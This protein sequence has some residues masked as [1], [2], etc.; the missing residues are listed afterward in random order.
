[1][2]EE[3]QKRSGRPCRSVLA[4]PSLTSSVVGLQTHRAVITQA[5]ERE[6]RRLD[7]AGGGMRA[8]LEAWLLLLVVTVVRLDEQVA[9]GSECRQT[10]QGWVGPFSVCPDRLRPPLWTQGSRGSWPLSLPS[11]KA[12]LAF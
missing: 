8:G 12:T 11:T 2:L 1:M 6:C 7:G 5:E 4:S 9:A 10:A 3:T